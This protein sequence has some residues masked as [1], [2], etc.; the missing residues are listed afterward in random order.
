MQ[1]QENSATGGKSKKTRGIEN[2]TGKTSGE[3]A[4]GAEQG[5]REVGKE[6]KGMYSRVRKKK[7]PVCERARRNGSER[8]E[9]DAGFVVGRRDRL[10]SNPIVSASLH[11]ARSATFQTCIRLSLTIVPFG[12]HE[13]LLPHTHSTHKKHQAGTQ[14]Q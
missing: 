9:I 2:M 6:M 13:E 8:K 11:P 14:S 4:R 10:F 7:G 5:L 1:H 3:H 12:P